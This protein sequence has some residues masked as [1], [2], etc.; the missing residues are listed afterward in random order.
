[1]GVESRL[2]GGDVGSEVEFVEALY[3][4]SAHMVAEN[5]RRIAEGVGVS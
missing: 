5:A 1:M 2:I 4:Y 3:G